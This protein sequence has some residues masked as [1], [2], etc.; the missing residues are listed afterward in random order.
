MN[1]FGG[2]ALRTAKSWPSSAQSV[3]EIVP[4]AAPDEDEARNPG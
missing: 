2:V 1:E 3:W 4:G